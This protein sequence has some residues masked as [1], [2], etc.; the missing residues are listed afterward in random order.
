VV[1]KKEIPTTLSRLGR[2]R[3]FFKALKWYEKSIGEDA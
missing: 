3:W 1:F 2:Y